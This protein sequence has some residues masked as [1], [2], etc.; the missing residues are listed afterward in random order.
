MFFVDRET[1]DNM[2]LSAFWR[3]GV[4]SDAERSF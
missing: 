3:R 2:G 4:A 1:F